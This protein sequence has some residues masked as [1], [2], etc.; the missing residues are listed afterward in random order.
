MQFELTIDYMLR[1]FRLFN[2]MYF[3]GCL[4]VPALKTGR[5][6]T[7]LGTFSCRRRKQWLLGGPRLCDFVIR[8]ST[9]Y[10]M[11]EKDYQNVLLHEMIHYYIAYKGI[12]DTSPHGDVFRMEMERINRDGWQIAV[13]HSGGKLSPA[14]SARSKPRLI[15]ALTLKDGGHLI[16]VVNPKYCAAIER[17]ICRLNLPWHGWYVGEDDYFDT[18]AVV[19]TLRGRKISG[20][21]MR[22]KLSGLK[23]CRL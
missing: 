19:R 8:L 22:E 7:S 23:Q 16:S 3:D 4:P 1:E 2:A 10:S 17:Q 12:K 21:L 6:R 18:F 13:R 11:T 9:A 14:G 15:L 5:A 20:G